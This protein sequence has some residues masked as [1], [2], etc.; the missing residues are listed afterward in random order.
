[1]CVYKFRTST[2][3]IRSLFTWERARLCPLDKRN[4][5]IPQLPYNCAAFYCCRFQICRSVLAPYQHDYLVAHAFVNVCCV[6]YYTDA[7][8]LPPPSTVCDCV[9]S[10]T[11]IGFW[12]WVRRINHPL[13]KFRNAHVVSEFFNDRLLALLGAWLSLVLV[14][15]LRSN[16]VSFC[17]VINAAR[18][19][20]LHFLSLISYS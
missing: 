6:G 19:C 9:V 4:L 15:T 18:Q 2:L 14:N 8:S 20:V 13:V 16:S 1:M 3:A 10:I 7:R 11:D 12:L 5:F 17:L